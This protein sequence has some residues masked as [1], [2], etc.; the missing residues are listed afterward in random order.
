VVAFA[1]LVEKGRSLILNACRDAVELLRKMDESAPE[2][3]DVM[4]SKDRAD[5]EMAT[6]RAEKRRELLEVPTAPPGDDDEA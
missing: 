6:W 1:G 5:A 3:G 2:T 4:G